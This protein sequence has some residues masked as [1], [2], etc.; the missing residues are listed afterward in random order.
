MSLD[1]LM[2]ELKA[3]GNFGHKG[4]PGK[5]GGSLSKSGNG[6]S[7]IPKGWKKDSN[8]V[9]D[10]NYGAGIRGYI[11][12]DSIISKNPVHKDTAEIHLWKR[13]REVKGKTG[14]K[15][16]DAFG[17]LDKWAEEVKNGS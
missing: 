14:V 11:S 17:I 2:V 13:G 5:R 7:P 3:R 12:P 1:D 9:M 10:K 8:G 4:R 6:S 16:S 15:I